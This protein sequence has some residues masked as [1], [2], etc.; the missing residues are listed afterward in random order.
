VHDVEAVAEYT[1]TPFV[2][3]VPA[4]RAAQDRA[5]VRDRSELAP[6]LGA[7]IR[8]KPVLVDRRQPT[9][10]QTLLRRPNRPAAARRGFMPLIQGS[11]SSDAFGL[12]S[13]NRSLF[14][15]QVKEAVMSGGDLEETIENC[16][17]ALAELVNGN[18]TRWEAL[19]SR[20]DDVTLGN[21]FGPFVRG[22]QDV[23]ATAAAAATRYRDGE[24]IGFDRVGTYVSDDLA[25][26]VEVE[27]FRAKVGGSDD[28]STVALRVSST[29]RRENGEWKIVHRHADPIT[30]AQPAR[31]VVQQ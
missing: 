17:V 28:L 21:P 22:R 7:A 12:G 10:L 9:H 23:V 19:L 6:I 20:Q 14:I 25:C 24:I 15:G 30:T 1:F 29:F 4:R 8:G 2:R 31:S 18:S 13:A 5:P 16:H 11:I 3:A 27:R 26:I